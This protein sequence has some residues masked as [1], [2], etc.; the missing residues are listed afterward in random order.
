MKTTTTLAI[1]I[2]CTALFALAGCE[3]ADM[4]PPAEQSMYGGAEGSG[5]LAAYSA[6]AKRF[7]FQHGGIQLNAPCV[8]A[9]MVANIA[10][11]EF[12]ACLDDI[13]IVG[14]G[15]PEPEVGEHP[16]PTCSEAIN[17]LQDALMHVA[18]MCP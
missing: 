16:D 17:E 14:P 1:L 5:E 3:E 6:E 18:S 12:L 9:R 11:R 13:I 15:E 4:Q 7:G 2:A 8:R 10:E